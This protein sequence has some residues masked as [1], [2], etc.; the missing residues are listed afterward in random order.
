MSEGE[1]QIDLV[2]PIRITRRDSYTDKCTISRRSLYIILS[3]GHKLLHTAFK[4]NLAP[5]RSTPQNNIQCPVYTKTNIKFEWYD[6][7]LRLAFK[8]GNQDSW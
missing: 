7:K 2:P 4:C 3:S 6:L 8:Y 5:M 1:W